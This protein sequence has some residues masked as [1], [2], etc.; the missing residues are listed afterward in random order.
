MIYSDKQYGISSAQ[1]AKL[2][3]ALSAA[4]DRTSD[5]AWLKKAEIDG[6]K[7]LID[8]IEAELAEYN[9]RNERGN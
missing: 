4:K 7:S 2:R 8:D 5:Q 1:L 9:I 6:L 3:D